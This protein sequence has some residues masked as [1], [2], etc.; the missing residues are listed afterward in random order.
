MNLEEV[1]E[2]LEKYN[3]QTLDELE[4]YL[5]IDNK[6][7]EC[8]DD[9][10]AEVKK[11]CTKRQCYEDVFVPDC[12]KIIEI[13]KKYFK[14]N[15]KSK[16]LFIQYLSDHTSKSTSSI[17]NYLSCKSCNQ[18]MA[19]SIHSSLKIVDAYFKKNFCSNLKKKFNYLTLFEKDYFSI[20][21]FLLTEHEITKE[22]FKVEFTQ[23]KEVLTK[24]EE[25]KIFDLTLVS[26]EILKKN[27]L[28]TDNMQGSNSYKMNLALAAFNRNLIDESDEIVDFLLCD[29]DFQTN[30]ELLQLKAKI[31]SIQKRDKDAIKILNK[32]VKMQK[33]NIDTETHNLLAASIKRDA[34]N[35][36][37]L[38]KDEEQLKERLSLSKDN[39]YSVYKL[40]S[41]YYPALNY[42]YLESILAYIEH[43][44]EHIKSIRV[45]FETI[46]NNL[47]HRVNDWWSY[48]SSM[49]YLILRGEYSEVL[50]ELKN[51]FDTIDEFE[52]ND[53]NIIST[54][55]Q[56][57][58]FSDFCTDQELKEVINL[59]K[60]YSNKVL[61]SKKK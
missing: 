35:E 9:E 29:K 40:N 60:D 13:Y 8:I 57:E 59:L 58:L 45:E 1:A 21:Q 33:P 17:E 48:I 34:F 27:L 51:H 18:Q 24:E 46:W 61:E 2:L 49:E 12:R 19:R 7:D 32:L 39:Y 10:K 44:M 4:Y 3:I 37:K 23:E 54:V 43:D 30:Q 14:N 25:E 5:D 50:R 55:R 56:L 47:N 11:Y 38:Y 16:K 26:K 53:F 22:S 36:F 28:D 6:T 41:D 20:K 52:I 31:L 42:M 15:V